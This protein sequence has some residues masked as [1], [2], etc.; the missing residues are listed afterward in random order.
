M[1]IVS[2]MSACG[3]SV[4]G[5]AMS[6]PYGQPQTDEKV[7][8]MV[9]QTEPGAAVELEAGRHLE[10]H[11]V[12]KERLGSCCRIDRSGRNKH[13]PFGKNIES[14]GQRPVENQRLG[15]QGIEMV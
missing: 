2:S 14:F 6:V 13:I 1:G 15:E 11:A 9:V 4:S 12:V 7:V 8:R 3:S 5:H 10:S